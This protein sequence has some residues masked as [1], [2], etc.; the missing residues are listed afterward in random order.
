M[1][2]VRPPETRA[3]PLDQRDWTIVVRALKRYSLDMSDQR[4]FTESDEAG[5]LEIW[6]KETLRREGFNLD[7]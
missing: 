5:L 4:A 3:L 2:D 1:A 6:I 7:H